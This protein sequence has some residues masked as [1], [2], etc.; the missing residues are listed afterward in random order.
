MPK[1]KVMIIFGTRPEAIKMA[2]VIKAFKEQRKLF[3][4]IV[5]VSGQHRAMLDQ[6]LDIFKIKPDIDLNLMQ[7]NQSLDALTANAMKVLTKTLLGIKPDLV[8]V[9]GD[10]TTAMVAALAAFYQKIPV[11][12]VEAGLR[13][14]DIYQPFPE[15]I[16]RRII[17]TLT[18][19]H[20][21]PT[22]S[23]F[24]ALLN[25][26]VPKSRIYLTGN[27]VIDAL[28]T[29]V[30]ENKEVHLGFDIPNKRKLILVT[31]HRRENFGRPIINIC[32]ALKAIIEQNDNVEIVY[33]VHLNPNIKNP[34][35]K[36]L[37]GIDRIHLIHP[38]DYQG[39]TF[40]LKK[41]YLVLTDSGG[42]QEEAPTFGKPV[43]VMR[44]KTERPEGVSAGVAK[45]VGTNT[46]KIVKEVNLLLRNRNE[47]KKMSRAINPY[48]DGKAA[49][50]IVNII[51]KEMRNNHQ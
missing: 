15:E 2:P 26:G 19:Y 30:R 7:E 13:T 39:V 25:E 6:V 10:T 5:C 49:K 24:T 44:N 1:F 32:R 41:A 28:K 35:Y 45:L 8:L 14:D 20:F 37:S 17:S 23:S 40:L 18:T 50:R 21:A 36:M 4:T 27:T 12:H 11:G 29:I 31:A 43:L 51:I 22:K 46:H 48:G 9:Q 33:P 3:S 47:Y 16:N 34:V 38:I 42:I